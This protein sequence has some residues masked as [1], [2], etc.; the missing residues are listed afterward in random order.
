[1]E[2]KTQRRQQSKPKGDGKGKLKGSRPDQPRRA[3]VTEQPD[4]DHANE[5]DNEDD[6]NDEIEDDQQQDG[7]ADDQVDQNDDEAQS[8][9]EEEDDLSHQISEILTVTAKKLSSIVQ[10]RKFGNPPAAKK[11]VADRKRTSHCAACGAQGHWAGDAEC[12]ASGKKT[13]AKGSGTQRCWQRQERRQGFIVKD[14][15]ISALHR[16]TRYCEDEADCSSPEPTTHRVL[17]ARV[18]Q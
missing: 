15:Q 7:D 5:P 6:P 13:N 17:V 14:S 8:G 12:T 10:A 11:S 1:M 18:H 16:P 4:A 2:A 3:L 9:A